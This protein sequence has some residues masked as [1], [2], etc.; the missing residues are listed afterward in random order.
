MRQFQLLPESKLNKY[1][2]TALL[3]VVCSPVYYLQKFVQYALHSLHTINIFKTTQAVG[4]HLSAF[5]FQLCAYVK[6]TSERL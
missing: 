1:N 3:L 5:Y 6:N 4:N 2:E